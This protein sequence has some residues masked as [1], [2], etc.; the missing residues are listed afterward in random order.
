M[1]KSL[2]ARLRQDDIDP[3]LL[4][5]LLV[6]STAVQVA[7]LIVRVTASYR[8]VELDLPVIWLGIVSGAFA[9]IPIGLAVWVGRFN[10]RGNDARANW[11]G[12]S[13]IVIA[14]GGF[15]LWPQPLPLI[16]FTVV[17]GI[18]HLFV[19]ASQQML[20][21]RCGGARG[22]ESV[23]GSYMVVSAIGQGIGPL[24]VGWAGGGATTPPTGLLFG[25]G[26]AI[27][28]VI[29]ASS[30]AIRSGATATAQPG[31]EK[32]PV[33]TLLRV[34][35]LVAVILTSVMIATASDLVVIYLPLLGAERSIDV[36]A[37]GLLLTVR[38][39]AS[40][41]SRVLYPRFVRRIDRKRLMVAST[42]AGAL[43]F[44]GLAIP[45]PLPLVYVAMAVMGFSLGLAMTLSM[46]SVV[47][48]TRHGMRGIANSL[49]LLGNR[50]GQFALP[51]GAGVVATATGAGGIFVLIALGLGASA[52]TVHYSRRGE[53]KK[54]EG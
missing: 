26:F 24:I 14:C 42:F 27:T 49:R 8:I 29:L 54:P 5:P 22:M 20:C 23:F 31:D 45:M 13:L 34:P 39:A 48:L 1:F 46:T 38:A 50:I 4:I 43:S 52:A 53:P 16:G 44:L 9:L 3:R 2:H 33:A 10:D 18:G 41:V 51:I 7:V 28:L 47:E 6:N 12:S 15:V 37:I 21:V 35:G 30:V 19:I 32:V 17:L 11:I 40:M 36:A 25:V